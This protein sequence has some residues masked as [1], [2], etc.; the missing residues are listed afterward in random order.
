GGERHGDAARPVEG[1]GLWY[2]APAGARKGPGRDNAIRQ[3]LGI[4]AHVYGDTAVRGAGDFAGRRGRHAQRHLV[5]GCFTLRDGRGASAIPGK[6]RIR[7]ERGNPAGTSAADYA[8]TAANSAKRD[9]PLPR[10]GSR[11]ALPERG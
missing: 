3:I 4:A 8:A 2:F 9:R 11:A 6:H 5:A 7:T 10:Q 1:S